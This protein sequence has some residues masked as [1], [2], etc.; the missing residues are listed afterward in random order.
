[1]ASRTEL[2]FI[3]SKGVRD[4]VACE[5]NRSKCLGAQLAGESS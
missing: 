1:M 3:S 2:V 4:I 5:G